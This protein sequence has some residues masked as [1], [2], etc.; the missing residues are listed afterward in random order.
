MH[1]SS[2]ISLLAI[3]TESLNSAIGIADPPQIPWLRIGFALLFC[4]AIGI[5]AIFA[6]RR[7]SP[8]GLPYVLKSRIGRFSHKANIEIIETRRA[9]VHGHICLFHYRGN[10]YLVAITPASATLM[11]KMPI[12]AEGSAG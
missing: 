9:S 5:G 1:V 6:L 4:L 2:L 8:G 7:Y 10:A 12:E 11:D 3:G